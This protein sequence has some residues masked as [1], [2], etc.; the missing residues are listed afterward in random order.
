MERMTDVAGPARDLLSRV[1]LLSSLNSEQLA[2]LSDACDAREA[3]AGDIVFRKGDPGDALYIVESGTLEAVLDEGTASEQVI[4]RFIPGDFFGEMALLTGQPRSATVRARSD[5]RLLTLGKAPFDHAVATDPALALRLSQA[6]SAR[7]FDTNEQMSRNRTRIC[8]L[9]AIGDGEATAGLLI[10]L[11]ES[12]RAHRGRRS[13]VVILGVEPPPALGL[14]AGGDRFHLEAEPIPSAPAAGRYVAMSAELL[15]THPDAAIAARLDAL[16]QHHHQVIVWT[17]PEIALRRRAALHRSAATVVMGAGQG[18]VGD[19]I[20]AMDMRS[21]ELDAPV[22]VALTDEAAIRAPQLP[23]SRFPTI[24]LGGTGIDSLARVMMGAS[25]G[26]ALSGGAAQGLAHLGVLEALLEAKIPIDM[27][28]GTSGGALYGSMI[29]SGL[30]I[31]AAQARVILQTRRN[32]IDKADLTLPR[33]GIIRGKR[34]ERMIR[35]AIGDITFDQLKYPFRAVATDL[36]NG[37]EV[38]LSHGLVYRAVRASISIPGIFEPVRIDGRLLVDG[39]VVTPLP[40]RPVRA[41]GADF[42]IAVHVPAP[43]RV[44]D[45][46]KRAAGKKLDEQHNMISTIFRSYAF[47]GDVLAQKASLEADVCIRP[48]VALFG[49]RDY[50]S[51][52]DIIHAGRLAGRASVEK[53]R[54]QLP[55]AAAA[56]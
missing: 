2:A 30:S 49:W 55:V 43:G 47:A 34:I 44:S 22:R 37:D 18:V 5:V 14:P 35:E 19:V 54:T 28:A 56:D 13:V 31:E 25:I 12:L 39:A 3:R 41:M 10:R 7:L 53:I 46:R 21:A 26:L 52:V 45:E 6:L 36:E 11:M 1:P 48:D 27:I 8:T 24:W 15:A 42:V 38:V 20:R 29:A 50:K 23:A 40:V 33:Y 9:I 4:S 51:A 32:L 16:R 17:S